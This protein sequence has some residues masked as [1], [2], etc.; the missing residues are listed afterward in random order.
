MSEH[1]LS[2]DEV[3]AYLGVP[4]E[5]LRRWRYERRGPSYVRPGKRVR[6]RASDVEAY[7]E[8]QRVEVATPSIR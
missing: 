5:T 1:L 3:S 4:V 2:P 8:A 6:Y 7:L